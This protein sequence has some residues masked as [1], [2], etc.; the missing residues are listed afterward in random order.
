ML[1]VNIKPYVS[2]CI[3]KLRGLYNQND[4]QTDIKDSSCQKI[5]LLLHKEKKIH[6]ARLFVN[7]N[8]FFF[9]V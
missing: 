4:N 6:D 7:A 1:Q 3:C 5:N 9:W 8:F 2:S